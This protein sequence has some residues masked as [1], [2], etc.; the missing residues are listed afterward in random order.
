MQKKK[1]AVLITTGGIVILGIPTL[2]YVYHFWGSKLSTETGDWGAFSDYLNPW[3]S[4]ANLLAIIFLTVWVGKIEGDREAE[5][6]KF[7]KRIEK[8]TRLSQEKIEKKNREFQ[9]KIILTETRRNALKDFI[10]EFKSFEAEFKKFITQGSS[11]PTASKLLIDEEKLKLS[12]LI[13]L[14]KDL[15]LRLESDR[16]FSYLEELIEK[17]SKDNWALYQKSIPDGN[18]LEQIRE[19]HRFFSEL[20]ASLQKEIADEW[21][22]PTFE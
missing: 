6:R 8:R 16:V 13:L 10:E 14:Y 5:N 4:F 7:Q 9:R 22:D 3:F 12:D 21:N 18:Y 19:V 11:G 1:Y 17:A 20:L 2:I 15:F